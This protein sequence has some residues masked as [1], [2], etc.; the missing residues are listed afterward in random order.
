MEA[1]AERGARFHP[2][3]GVVTPNGFTTSH[4]RA[5]TTMSWDLRLSVCQCPGAK[6]AILPLC[7]HSLCI[8]N[9]RVPLA[10]A[11]FN[12][13]CHT[14]YPLAR[15]R[16]ARLPSHWSGLTALRMGGSP[17]HPSS[18]HPPTSL[19]AINFQGQRAAFGSPGQWSPNTVFN[20]Q[21]KLTPPFQVP[22]TT[23]VVSFL[24]IPSQQFCNIN[25]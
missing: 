23:I 5:E 22:S 20:S 6:V 24:H 1:T 4:P 7:D 12:R 11:P 18:S 13:F 21:W 14:P 15:L 17:S 19:R 10:S 25:S 16:V 9:A 8:E 3:V 2:T